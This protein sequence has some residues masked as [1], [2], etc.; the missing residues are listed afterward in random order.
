MWCSGVVLMKLIQ[1][2]I[3]H[4]NKGL[5]VLEG[6]KVKVTLRSEKPERLGAPALSSSLTLCAHSIRKCEDSIFQSNKEG[7]D[8]VCDKNRERLGIRPSKDHEKVSL[9][10]LLAVL[11]CS[12]A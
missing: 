7:E 4:L 2:G 3:F 11:I 9:K 10:A 6:V 12:F 8:T 5:L 1:G